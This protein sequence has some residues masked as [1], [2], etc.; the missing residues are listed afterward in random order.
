VVRRPEARACVVALAVMARVLGA[1]DTTAARAPEVLASVDPAIW[2]RASESTVAPLRRVL[3]LHLRNASL[4]ETLDTVARQAGLEVA[5]GSDVVRVQS[6]ISL[7]ASGIPVGT[8]LNQALLGTHLTAYVSM[9][10]H[11]LL[12]RTPF[13]ARLLKEQHVIAVG[14]IVGRVTDAVTRRPLDQAVIRVTETDRSTTTNNV[15]RYRLRDVPLGTYH[16]LIRRLGY[17]PFTT[18]ITLRSDSTVVDAALHASATRLDEVVTTAVGERRRVEVGNVISTINVDSIAPTAPVTSLTDLISARAPGVEVVENSGLAGAGE[19]IRIRGQSSLIL[20]GD[21]IIIVDGV[22]QD[23]AAGGSTT[24]LFGTYGGNFE[25]QWHPTPT[26]LNDLDFTQIETIDILKGPSATTEYGTDA[27][28]GV[29]VITTKRGHAG[30]PQWS[31]NIEQT[32]DQVPTNRFQDS[33]WSWGHATGTNTPVQCPFWDSYQSNYSSTSGTCVVDSVTHSDPLTNSKT[34]I[35]GTGY[36]EK[37]GLQVSGGSETVRYFLAGGFSNE[38]GVVRVP[39]VFQNLIDSLQLPRS[40]LDPNSLEQ[41]SVRGNA[42][43]QLGARSD[44]TFN[45]AYLSTYQQT[46]DAGSLVSF[47]GYSGKPLTAANGYGYICSGSYGCQ[48]PATAFAAVGTQQTDRFTG[49]VTANWRPT[50]WFVAHG[51]AGLDHGSQ[52]VT[53]TTYGQLDQVLHNDSNRGAIGTQNTMTDVYTVDLRGSAKAQLFPRLRSTTSAGLQMVDTRVSGIVVSGGNFPGSPSLSQIGTGN[54]EY[55]AP[56]GNRQATL[57]GYVEEEAN[58]D[59]RLFLIGALRVDAGSG[60]GSQTH[61]AVYPKAS[62]SWLALGSDNGGAGTTTLRLRGSYGQSGVQPTNGAGLQLWTPTTV[63]LPGN[64]GVP[65]Y[66]LTQ[67]GNPSIKPERSEEFEGGLDLGFWKHRL[68]FSVTAYSKLTNDALVNTDLG[69]TLPYQGYQENIGRVSNNGIEADVTAVLVQSSLVTWSATVNASWNANK[70]LALAPGLTEQSVGILDTGNGQMQFRKGYPLYSY[71]GLNIGYRVPPNGGV[72]TLNDLIIPTDSSYAGNSLPA[73]EA[74]FSTSVGFLHGALRL[75]ALFD[76]R[77][78][79]KIANGVA[80]GVATNYLTGRAQ[81]DP[82]APY[83]DQARSLAASQFL[84]DNAFFENGDF[85]RFRE[86][87]LTYSL[88]NHLTRFAHLHSLSITA[89]VRNIWLWSGYSGPDPET[90]SDGGFNTNT[91]AGVTTVNNDIRE[92][93]GTVPLPRY[94]VLRINAGF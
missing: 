23:N 76:Y 46:P 9:D 1:Q 8:V 83:W 39:D 38:S 80:I 90:S 6:R 58:V 25:E 12:V 30:A 31:A 69:W 68:D 18:M 79:Y 89:A 72:L 42:T 85:V 45:A 13:P 84:A 55:T 33:Y 27:A 92:D 47:V 59:E 81:N 70:L 41:R 93:E 44:I 17:M 82:S 26:R 35:Y 50:S 29:I 60:F 28:N 75:N 34:T 20:Q 21:P 66:T 3:T 63:A 54:Y 86:L 57:G 48:S 11:Q 65:A 52:A 87:G 77:G 10:G 49:G 7:Q 78:G 62:V 74:S 24:A 40:L 43:A 37:Y 5:Y 36:R 94:Y 88:P 53:N 32:A 67:P 15:G 2:I 91:N 71:Y 73:R 56:I 51:T 64:S 19:A 4:S 61:S 16:V 22:R 14:S